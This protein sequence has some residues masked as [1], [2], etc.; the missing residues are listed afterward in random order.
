[1]PTF[2]GGD[3]STERRYW[4][5]LTARALFAIVVVSVLVLVIAAIAITLSTA[6]SNVRGAA[7]ATRQKNSTNNRVF[8]QQAFQQKYADYQGDIAKIM[9]A[10]SALSYDSAHNAAQS[11][12]DQDHTDLVGI[13]NHCISVAQD[14]NAQ[15]QFYL[16]K[17]FLDASLPSALD[18]KACAR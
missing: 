12:L 11:I 15:T 8:Q 1:M 9:T 2:Y 10:G 5:G 6:T 3:R 13:A 14:Y 18:P 7:G 16:A 17:Q 4:F